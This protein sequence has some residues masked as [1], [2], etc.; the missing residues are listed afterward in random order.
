GYLIAASQDI[1]IRST[2]DSTVRANI[3]GVIKQGNFIGFS[4]GDFK[5]DSEGV[6][7]IKAAVQFVNT[8]PESHK[9]VYNSLKSKTMTF[10]V[11]KGAITQHKYYAELFAKYP[12]INFQG[13]NISTMGLRKDIK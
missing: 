5:I 11:G 3:L 7:Y 1:R 4:T 13:K 10:Y 12:G 6:K 9:E 2:P 8:I